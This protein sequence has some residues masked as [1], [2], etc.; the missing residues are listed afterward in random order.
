MI[1]SRFASFS[2]DAKLTVRSRGNSQPELTLDVQGSLYTV[3]SW[4]SFQFSGVYHRREIL[5]TSLGKFFP[6]R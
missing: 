6:G 4:P 3:S 2:F 5:C 1:F